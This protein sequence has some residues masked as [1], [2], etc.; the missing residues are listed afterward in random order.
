MHQNLW[1]K[2]KP[3]M[4]HTLQ[5]QKILDCCCSAKITLQVILKD[6]RKNLMITGKDLQKT[7]KSLF[8]M[9]KTLKHKGMSDVCPKLPG[10][11]TMLLGNFSMDS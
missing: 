9:N 10:W 8:T 7:A 4:S 1:T 6:V 3:F 11:S 2:F 5:I